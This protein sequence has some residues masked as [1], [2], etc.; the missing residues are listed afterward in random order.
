MPLTVYTNHNGFFINPGLQFIGCELEAEKL[1]KDR[2][3]SGVKI[4]YDINCWDAV[5]WLK[6]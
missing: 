3:F 5:T 1:A 4:V 6:G 2:G